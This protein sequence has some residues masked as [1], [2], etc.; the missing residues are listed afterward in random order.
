[1]DTEWCE[2]GL[3]ARIH[4]LT[5][6]RLREQVQPVSQ[7]AFMGFLLRW[8]GIDRSAEAPQGE[9]ALARVLGQLEGVEAPAGAWETEILPARLPDYDPAWLD[10]LCARGQVMWARLSAPLA[11]RGG[12]ASLRATP[13]GLLG[14]ADLVFWRQQ[15]DGVDEGLSSPA[16]RVLETLDRHGASFFD[17]ILVHTALLRIQVEQ[18]LAELAARGQ[19]SSDAYAG[20]RALL[21]PAARRRPRRS[22]GRRPRGGYAL[23]DA[24][25]WSRIKGTADVPD[26]ARVRHIARVLLRRYGVVFRALLAREAGLPSWRELAQVYRS[27]EARGELRGGRFVEGYAGEQFARPEAIGALRR[28]QGEGLW[29]AISAA[30]PLNLV[31]V[32]SPG[33]RVPALAANR[34]LYRDGAPVAARLAGQ[35]SLFTTLDRDTQWQVH[36]LL[37]RRPP[38]AGLRRSPGMPPHRG[39]DRLSRH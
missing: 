18:A 11:S 1:V 7:A 2:R 23:E 33:A 30:D 22:H 32:V 29:I 15:P 3:L 9:E 4:R 19:V 25:R 14:R 8:Q 26:P 34:I 35:L 36:E 10:R 5:L 28:G 17:E 21:V 37:L 24:G 16:R 27:M 20:L 12:A 39:A 6:H 13:V 31:G 38:A